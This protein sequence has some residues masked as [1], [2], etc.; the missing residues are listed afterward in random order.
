M[1]KLKEE[2]MR[3]VFLLCAC[4]SVLAVALICVF[5]F[6][7]G[8]P[9]MA[10]IGFSGFLAGTLWKPTNDIYGIFPM[11]L[12]SLCVTAGPLS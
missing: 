11:I 4:V 7:S 8:L 1:V 3:A 10:K 5:L 9:A 12:G 6:S 2:L